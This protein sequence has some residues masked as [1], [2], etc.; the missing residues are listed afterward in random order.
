[1]DTGIIVMVFSHQQ[2]KKHKHNKRTRK[3]RKQ[4]KIYTLH[5]ESS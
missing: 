4:E 3:L 1:M 2:K 5:D